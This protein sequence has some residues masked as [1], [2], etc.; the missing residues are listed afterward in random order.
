MNG[1]EDITYRV[2][3][4][5]VHQ[6]DPRVVYNNID[7]LVRRGEAIL[8]SDDEEVETV[9]VNVEEPDTPT[10]TPELVPTEIMEESDTTE[11][12]GS[13]T[14]ETPA[15]SANESGLYICPHCGAEYATEKGLTRHITSKHQS[16]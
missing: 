7:D 16:E 6:V 4:R 5:G 1:P 13:D 14:V 11:A 12:T 8:Y 2:S 9:E 15:V 10:E 3:P